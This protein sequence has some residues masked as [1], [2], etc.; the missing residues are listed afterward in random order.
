MSLQYEPVIGFEIRGELL[1]KSTTDFR[2]RKK[3]NPDT[4]SRR[5]DHATPVEVV[6]DD[7]WHDWQHVEAPA[8][9]RGLCR[10]QDI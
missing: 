9:R 4:S 3:C 5:P 8:T 10:L 2:T 6:R 7:P 1:T